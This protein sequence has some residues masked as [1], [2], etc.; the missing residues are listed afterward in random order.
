MFFSPLVMMAYVYTMTFKPG[1]PI[2]RALPNPPP[3]KEY[4]LG[5]HEP[6]PSWD[7]LTHDEKIKILD[8]DLDGMYK[9]RGILGIIG[10]KSNLHM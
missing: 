10:L 5:D 9:R 6:D 7:C 2:D 4:P 1:D 8:D 3:E